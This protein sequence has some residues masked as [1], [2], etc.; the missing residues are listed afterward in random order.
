MEIKIMEFITRISSDAHI[1][2]MKEV[3][4]KLKEF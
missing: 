1:K 4:P 3:K 2:V